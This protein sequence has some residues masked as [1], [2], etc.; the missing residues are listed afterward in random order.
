MALFYLFYLQVGHG[1]VIQTVGTPYM[2]TPLANEFA[3]LLNFLRPISPCGHIQDLTLEGAERWLREI[4]SRCQKEVFYY[5]TEV[6]A[7]MC[8]HFPAAPCYLYTY[9]S[10]RKFPLLVHNNYVYGHRGS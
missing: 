3:W 9:T 2:G 7:C 1:R 10:L 8:S 5:T 6:S 4:P